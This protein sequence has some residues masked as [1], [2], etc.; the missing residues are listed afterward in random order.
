[1]TVL[2]PPLREGRDALI[3]WTA[4]PAADRVYTLRRCIGGFNGAIERAAWDSLDAS[5]KTWDMS[6]REESIWNEREPGEAVYSGEALSFTDRIPAGTAS[7]QY[8][9]T[10]GSSAALSEKADVL[11]GAP[12]VISGEDGDLGGRCEALIQMLTV[13]GAFEDSVLT[14]RIFV[15]G[16]LSSVCTGTGSMRVPAAADSRKFAE[17]EPG[18]RHTMRILAEDDLS[19]ADERNLSFT[20]LED[21]RPTSVYYLLRD[22]IPVAKSGEI[23]P[24]YDYAANGTHRYR[25]R[26]VDRFGGFADSDEITLTTHMTCSTLAPLDHPGQMCRLRYRYEN[27]PGHKTRVKTGLKTYCFEGRGTA[28]DTGEGG[29]AS[30]NLDFSAETREEYDAVRALADARVPVIYRDPFGNRAIAAIGSLPVRFREIAA[31]FSV[32]MTQIDEEEAIA[33]D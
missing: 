33:Y 15:D 22:G 32:E 3:R 14:V 23:V 10:T 26:A 17:M 28:V 24:F 8:Y 27:E 2:L 1:M 11:K 5:G 31:D 30:W 12:P 18:S 6:D 21:L 16:E 9:V 7:I 25:I 19:Y 20:V 29:S 4:S 13:T